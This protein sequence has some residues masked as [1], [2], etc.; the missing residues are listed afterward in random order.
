MLSLSR[1]P[2][3]RCFNPKCLMI[4]AET[5]PFPEPGGP[6]MTARSS[7]GTTMVRLVV[8][9]VLVVP[10]QLRAGR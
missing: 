3:E 9:M 4:R 10:V 8:V 6:M 1:S 7:G 2:L 5:V